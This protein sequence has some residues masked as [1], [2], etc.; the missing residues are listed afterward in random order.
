ML[1]SEEDQIEERY[2]KDSD[3]YWRTLHKELRREITTYN[4]EKGPAERLSI[5]AYNA[6]TFTIQ[7]NRLPNSPTSV[8]RNLERRPHRIEIVYLVTSDGPE[9]LELQYIGKALEAGNRTLAEVGFLII[10]SLKDIGPALQDLPKAEEPPD[11]LL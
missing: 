2:S 6:R 3:T 4:A 11:Y 9:D 10:Q 8:T 7:H 5:D 1:R